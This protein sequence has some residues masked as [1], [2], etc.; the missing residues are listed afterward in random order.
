MQAAN[1]PRQ[2]E[3][4]RPVPVDKNIFTAATSSKPHFVPEDVHPPPVPSV[5]NDDLENGPL[6]CIDKR[7]LKKIAGKCEEAVA[8]RRTSDNKLP[9]L[10]NSIG[11]RLK[12]IPAGRFT[13]SEGS[14]AHEVTLTQPFYLGVTQVTNAQWQAL[15]GPIPSQWKD[16]DHPVEQVSWKD[17]VSFCE[18]LTAM[19]D[20]RAT[21]RKYRLPT[22]AEW[23]HACRAGSTTRY[24]FSDDG[25]LLGDFG[26]FH[27]NSNS[28]TQPVGRKQPN[29]W[30]LHDMH[31]NV[32]EW[33]SDWYHEFA[34]CSMTD[35]WG[36]SQGSLR[37]SRGGCWDNFAEICRSAARYWGNPSIRYRYL[38]FRLALSSS[39]V[40]PP[41]AGK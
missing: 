20:E 1:A 14:D 33:C 18:K 10:T 35:P 39:E 38:G 2:S 7:R 22:E 41:K 25:S 17:A 36:P 34:H 32:W 3:S 37:V 24:S 15:M 13:M 12:L 28:Q 4:F 8:K 16:A 21:G 9:D 40:K 31:G 27:N 30:G 19:P 6:S 23:E 11:I 26:W 5:V 29:G